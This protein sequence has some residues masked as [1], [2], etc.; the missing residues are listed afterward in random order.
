ASENSSQL[1]LDKLIEVM[2]NPAFSHY[3]Q[4]NSNAMSMTDTSSDSAQVKLYRVTDIVSYSAQSTSVTS[5]AV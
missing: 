5:T 2:A 1:R 4:A 3:G